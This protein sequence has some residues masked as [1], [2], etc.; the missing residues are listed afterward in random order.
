M[1]KAQ[2]ERILRKL[3]WLNF[4]MIKAQEAGNQEEER[5]L[6]TE[7]SGVSFTLITLGYSDF[8]DTFLECECGHNFSLTG[9]E[10][11]GELKKH[12]AEMDN[13]YDLLKVGKCVNCK[14]DQQLLQ[15]DD[16]QV[17]CDNCAQ[18]MSDMAP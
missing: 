11:E 9:K 2:M 13:Y 8:L 14:A 16:G 1:D 15:L 10:T 5:L 6:E 3:R 7:L 4:A 17:I 12:Y 18:V